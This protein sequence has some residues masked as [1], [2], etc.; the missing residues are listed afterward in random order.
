MMFREYYFGI[1]LCWN[2]E[3]GCFARIYNKK[4]LKLF[5]PRDKEFHEKKLAIVEIMKSIMM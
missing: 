5:S 2:P 1:R 4:G 3:D